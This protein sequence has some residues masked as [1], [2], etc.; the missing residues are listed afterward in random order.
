MRR[1]KPAG[2][3]P[4]AKK[5]ATKKA[6]SKNENK[7]QPTAAS[8]EAFID[9]VENET[10]RRD[11][12]TLLTLMK[13]ITGEPPKMW[14]ASM[15]GFGKYRYKYESGREGEFF[16]TGFSPRAASLSVYILPGYEDNSDLLAKLGKHKTGKSCLYI[17]KLE[18]VD[19]GVLEKLIARSVA[20]MR[21][22]YRV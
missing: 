18:D 5:T 20:H 2:E 11:S 8:V 16:L 3:K 13:K 15:I 4:P 7:T 12:R 1:A 6:V 21:K 14:G 17:N 9:G 10:R 22:T 19:L